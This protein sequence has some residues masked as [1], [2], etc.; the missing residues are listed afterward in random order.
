MRETDLLP[1]AGL[2]GA[3]LLPDADLREMKR[4]DSKPMTIQ[5]KEIA[6]VESVEISK[7]TISNQIQSALV[8]SN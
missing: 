3:D 5:T 2:P 6:T 1:D 7:R 4:R 8:A